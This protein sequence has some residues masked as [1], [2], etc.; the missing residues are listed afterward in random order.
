MLI[1]NF[2]SA[3]Q[4]ILLVRDVRPSLRH[5]RRPSRS[6]QSHQR[7]PRPIFRERRGP[8]QG[9]QLPLLHAPRPR[10][11]RAPG[12]PI[13]EKAVQAHQSGR[14]GSGDDLGAE[15]RDVTGGGHG[16]VGLG[17]VGHRHRQSGQGSEEGDPKEDDPEEKEGGGGD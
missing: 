2:G 7:R 1:L 9:D 11:P 3:D 16:D 4:N 5:L 13:P 17:R 14:R 10:L 8:L 15:G 12:V 6:Q